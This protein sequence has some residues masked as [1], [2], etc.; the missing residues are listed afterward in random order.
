MRELKLRKGLE[1]S[2]ICDCDCDL[3][4]LS[5]AICDYDLPSTICNLRRWASYGDDDDGRATVSDG[6]GARRGR[7]MGS[8]SPPRMVLSCPIL[9]PPRMT[10]KTFPPHPRPLGP[11]EAPPHSIK[12]Y[13]LIICPTTSTIFFNET[14]FI[15]KNI[16]EITTK[17][18]PSNQINF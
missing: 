4:E 5:K 12:L 6:N 8:S 13:F 10:G 16:L 1:G 9:A 11:R 15:D 3:P 18:I 7:R 14:Y 17:F 2:A